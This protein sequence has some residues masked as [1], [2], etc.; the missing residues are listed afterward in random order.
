MIKVKILSGIWKDEVGSIAG[1]IVRKEI[2]T[3][4][5][6]IIR[7]ELLHFHLEELEVINN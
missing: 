2:Y 4:A 1:F 6:V 7:N 5:I 3:Y